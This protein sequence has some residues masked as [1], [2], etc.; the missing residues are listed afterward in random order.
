MMTREF[1]DIGADVVSYSPRPV[2]VDDPILT[3][4]H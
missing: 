3:A 2:G 1:D 4:H